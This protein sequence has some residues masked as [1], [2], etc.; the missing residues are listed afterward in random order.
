RAHRQPRALRSPVHV[1]HQLAPDLEAD[2]GAV[3]LTRGALEQ[4]LRLGAADLDLDRPAGRQL[5]AAPAKRFEAEAERIDVLPPARHQ[6]SARASSASR[7][8]SRTFFGESS[9]RIS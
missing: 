3:R 5:G 4:E 2:V 1:V 9:T 6:L 7:P 8:N